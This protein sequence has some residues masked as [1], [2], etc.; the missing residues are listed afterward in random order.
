MQKKWIIITIILVFMATIWL[1]F[2]I[3]QINQNSDF[4]SAQSIEGEWIRPD[5]GYLLKI[6]NV[7]AEGTIGVSYFNPKSIHV[8]LGMW[9]IE[10]NK[11]YLFIEL[12]DVNYPGSKYTL[13]YVKDEDVL[14]GTYLQAATNQT[15]NVLFVRKRI[16]LRP[17]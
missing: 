5:G 15:Y 4:K 12:R 14:R 6:E 2:V 16:D 10:E 1:V 7:K 17:A 11:L 13:V 9:K 3:T 8:H